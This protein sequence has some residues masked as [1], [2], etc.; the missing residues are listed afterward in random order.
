MEPTNTPICMQQIACPIGPAPLLISP[1]AQTLHVIVTGVPAINHST[2]HHAAD[3][4]IHFHHGGA[5]QLLVLLVL[6]AM[7]WNYTKLNNECWVSVVFCVAGACTHALVCTS[8]LL[9]WERAAKWH[10]PHPE[11]TL[12]LPALHG[13]AS[14]RR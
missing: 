2:M 10:L 8:A 12:T 7:C 11:H 14:T 5:N 13:A 3:L 1:V 4:L 6:F 9:S